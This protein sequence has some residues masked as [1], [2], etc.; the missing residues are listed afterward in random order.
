MANRG[1]TEL[2]KTEVAKDEIHTFILVHF[3]FDTPEYLTDAFKDVLFNGNNYLSSGNLI[4][5]SNVK[6]SIDININKIKVSVSGVNAANIAIALTEDYTDKKVNIYRGLFDDNDNLIADP[7]SIFVNG[8]VSNFSFSENYSDGTAE[9]SWDVYSHWA[10][11]DRVS[12]RRTND[13]DQQSYYPGDL[14]MEFTS[15]VIKDL[16]WGNAPEPIKLTASAVSNWDGENA[17]RNGARSNI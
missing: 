10:D 1:M 2:A 15:S 9:L 11:F 17:S 6:E 14:G 16:G 7:I 8:R 4:S 12:G 13:A 5:I 3:E